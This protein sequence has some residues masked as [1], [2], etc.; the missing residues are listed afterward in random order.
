MDLPLYN[1]TQRYAI[2][3]A[4]MLIFI[5]PQFESKAGETD[6]KIDSSIERKATMIKAAG[7]IRYFHPHEA[8]EEAEWEEVLLVGLEY[9]RSAET[10][11]E[12]LAQLN[13]LL[14]PIGEGIKISESP[15]YPDD[16]SCP[17]QQVPY[18][19]EHAGLGNSPAQIEGMQQ[20]YYSRRAQ[21]E[22]GQSEA[23]EKLDKLADAATFTDFKFSADFHLIIPVALCPDD[24]NLKD[25]HTSHLNEISN[26]TDHPESGAYA[27]T[28]Q[29]A[30][31]DLWPAVEHFY[32]Y[33]EVIDGSWP[34]HLKTYLSRA[35][36]AESRTDVKRILQKMTAKMQDGHIIVSDQK[37]DTRK[38]IPVTLRYVEDRFVVVASKMEEFAFGDE[39]IEIDGSPASEWMKK[40]KAWFG[41]S[42]HE[43]RTKIA[44]KLTTGPKDTRYRYTIKRDGET[45]EKQIDF[46]EADTDQMPPDA[47]YR[48]RVTSLE[49][50]IWY[51]DLRSAEWDEFT[52]Y[53]DA[54]TEAEAVIF[55]LRGYP[56]PQDVDQLFERIQ[57]VAPEIWEPFVTM[58]KPYP[59]EQKVALQQVGWP[60]ITATQ[61]PVFDGDL[62]FLT[63]GASKSFP[64]SI[65]G[66]VKYYDVGKI[67]GKP[68]AGANGN[69]LPILL[70]G[71]FMVP[72][73]YM[74]VYGPDG[75]I[76]HAEGLQPDIYVKP[77]LDGIRKGKDEILQTAIEEAGGDPANALMPERKE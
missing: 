31:A 70:P 44:G 28:A 52:P 25:R 59:S 45:I 2:P 62:L 56:N 63:D 43:V 14:T 57:I 60:F 29:L 41:G 37:V 22:P 24:A 48:E 11:E 18:R 17:E 64:E 61:E 8:V 53:L 74:R 15:D 27:K 67:V 6:E 10:D 72:A 55:D 39:V 23:P 38:S 51:A 42:G 73:T 75:D 9:A 46:S 26:Q 50:G 71:E 69:V 5:I 36:D 3:A 30:L 20:P 33:P 7:L 19:W 77:T 13:E 47:F 12:F 68:T 21:V 1:F 32:P 76:Y 35:R 4:V 16:L 40:R 65:T 66:Y 49:E 34:E 58:L 54:L